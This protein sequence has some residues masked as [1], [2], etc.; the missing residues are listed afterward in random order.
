MIFELQ[1][2]IRFYL[3]RTL[4][5]N[6]HNIKR[7]TWEAFEP[8][9]MR[10]KRY[11]KIHTRWK[12][13]CLNAMLKFYNFYLS[14]S[15]TC[16]NQHFRC[17]EIRIFEKEN[18]NGLYTF[19][20]SVGPGKSTAMRLSSTVFYIISALKVGVGGKVLYNYVCLL[21]NNEW[22]LYGS[23]YFSSLQRF[24]EKRN[25]VSFVKSS[26]LLI[27]YSTKRIEWAS[28]SFFWLASNIAGNKAKGWI[29]NQVFQK[30]QRT[31]N[32]LKNK[33]FLP[34]DAYTYVRKIFE[35]VWSVFHKFCFVH[36]WIDC[37][38]LH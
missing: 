36:S 23:Y 4:K 2:E 35:G 27:L 20:M 12:N 9:C 8:T 16:Q 32:F 11:A 13:N 33:P 38:F 26:F 17:L 30:K 22:D 10:G 5:L 25:F 37:P 19:K 18:W 6:K 29:L 21:S 28:I 7:N 31:P 3:H 15:G 34:L 1:N 24:T 14:A